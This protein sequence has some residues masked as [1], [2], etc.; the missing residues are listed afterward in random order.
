[1][2]TAQIIAQL[3]AERDAIDQAIAALQ[4]SRATRG[5]GKRRRLSADARKRMSRA[6]K[7]RWAAWKKKK[8]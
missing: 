6:Q 1:M 5:R 8:K 2:N 4:G 3:E 7:R